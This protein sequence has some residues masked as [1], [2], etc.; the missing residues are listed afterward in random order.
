MN[1]SATVRPRNDAGVTGCSVPGASESV[2]CLRDPAQVVVD[3]T[4][5]G[6]GGPFPAL[7]PD[8]AMDNECCLE[9]GRGILKPSTLEINGGDST[10]DDPFGSAVPHFAMDG[11]GRLEVAATRRRLAHLAE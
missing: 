2:P 6:E 11:E 5:V 1:V 10:E 4:K 3:A 7:I 8:L 9:I